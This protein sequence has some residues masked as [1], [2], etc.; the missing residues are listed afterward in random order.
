MRE[1]NTE[2]QEEL[3][4]DLAPTKVT[5]AMKQKAKSRRSKES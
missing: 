4:Q 3:N 2:E 1:L 5:K